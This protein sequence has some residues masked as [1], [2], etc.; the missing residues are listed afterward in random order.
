MLF[1]SAR[2]ISVC[3][4]TAALLII[5]SGVANAASDSKV[6]ETSTVDT[7]S[8]FKSGQPIPSASLTSDQAAALDSEMRAGC[9]GRQSSA[10]V[11]GA[12]YLSQ[13]GCSFIGQ[14]ASVTRY[15]SW[16]L[17]QFVNSNACVK[18]RGYTS[19][20]AV[21]WVSAGCGGSGGVSVPWGAVASVAKI[22]LSSMG[23]T[24]TT[25]IWY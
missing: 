21:T 8:L 7:A 6:D 19:S 18:A 24:G 23:V 5:S 1:S 4:A 17:A 25:I 12:F 2:K 22:Q 3:I 11:G 9:S 10:P 15:Y 13:D 16:Q 14:N 20:S